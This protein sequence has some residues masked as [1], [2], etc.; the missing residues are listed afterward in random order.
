MWD[1]I[2][3][4]LS[5]VIFFHL[6]CVM[7]MLEGMQI[8]FYAVAKLKPSERGKSVFAKKTCALLFSGNNLPGFMIGRQLSVVS[9]MLFVAR[10]T[11]VSIKEGGD[12][13]FGVSDSIQAF[14]NTGLLGALILTIVGSIAWQL[15]ASAFPLAFLAN[16]FMV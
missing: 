13:L 12:N 8:A 5:L 2:P 16:P 3:P 10:A 1:G 9:C 6:L 4:T 11:S 15:V 14:F 7:G